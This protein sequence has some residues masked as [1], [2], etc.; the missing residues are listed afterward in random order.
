MRVF[1]IGF[2]ELLVILVIAL[3]A[4][5]PSKLPDLARA[6]GRGISEIRKATNEIKDTLEQD[7]TV[8]EI[9]K[10]FQSA[11]RGVTLDTLGTFASTLG[12]T[13]ES[14]PITAASVTTDPQAMSGVPEERADKDADDGQ[15]SNQPGISVAEK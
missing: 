12:D 15:P 5:G 9:K 14:A 3:I 8:K 2:Q 11:Q 6:L 4:V 1:D 10:E 7:E 13:G